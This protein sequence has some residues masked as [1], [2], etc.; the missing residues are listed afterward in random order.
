[1]R[2][3]AAVLA[4]LLAAGCSHGAKKKLAPAP[5]PVERP[6]IALQAARVETLGF[7]GLELVFDCRIEN[8]NPFP[9]SV[10]RVSYGLALEGRKAVSGST[11]APLAVAAASPGA[12]G[13][14]SFALPVS[15]RLGNVP[16]FGRLLALDRD[17]TYALTGEVTFE[18]PAGRVAVPLAQTG[19]VAVPRAPRFQAGKAM[20]RSAS[21]REVTLEMLV[22]V[23]NPNTFPIPSG[24]IRYALFLSDREV[25]RTDVVLAE[26]IPA[27]ESTAVSVP[28]RISV[29]KA[30]T[31]AARLLIP[32]T[33]LDAG[34]KGEAVFDG[35]PVPLD[36]ATSILPGR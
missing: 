35:V 25:A 15:V 19:H 23:Q 14:A 31:A 22:G 4:A 3:T 17:A 9:L 1:M 36:L 11:S 10:A 2:S 26:P 30:G 32:F 29:L 6:A 20:L 27:G 28:I 24:R 13:V 5:L 7:A 21:P 8:P 34:V 33:S 12:A 16:A 18:T